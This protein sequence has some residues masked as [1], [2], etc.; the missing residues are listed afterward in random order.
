MRTV[1]LSQG[2]AAWGYLTPS[3]LIIFALIVIPLGCLGVYSFWTLQDTGLISHAFT[4]STWTQFF[5]DAYYGSVFIKTLR[6]AL[7]VTLICA[8]VG[9]PAAYF[10]TLVGPRARGMLIVLLFLPTWISYVV[11]TMSWIPV[12]GKTGLV[13]GLLIKLGLIDQPAHLLYN[14]VSVYMGMV[15][16]LLPIMILNIF[17][18]LQTVDRNLVSAART[19]GATDLYVFLSVIFPLALP[20]LAAGSLLCFILATGAY[21]TPMLL[22]GPDAKYFSNVLFETIVTQL[23]WPTGAALSLVLVAMLILLVYVYG[24][25]IGLATIIRAVKT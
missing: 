9:Y 15:H 7:F 16:F 6:L 3:L 19:L 10:L 5:A 12:L 8:I 20:G 1:V 23:D 14:N 2:K 11:R 24:R 13:N 17:I 18:G 21:I 25:V 22:G 4:M